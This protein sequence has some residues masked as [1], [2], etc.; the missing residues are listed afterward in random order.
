MLSFVLPNTPLKFISME[1]E[2]WL[3][4]WDFKKKKCYWEHLKEHIENLKN[5]YEFHGNT[6]ETLNTHHLHAKP[7]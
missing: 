3:N 7:P 1:I 2:P 5:I 6:M 4:K